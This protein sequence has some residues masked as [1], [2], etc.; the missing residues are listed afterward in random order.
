[1]QKKIQKLSKNMKK[2]RLENKL[3]KK[4]MANRLQMK[5]DDYIQLEKGILSCDIE[6]DM[7]FLA[8]KEFGTKAYK[9]LM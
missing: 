7:L 1:M 3:S 9:L 4:Q 5:K 2:L 8:E 6:I